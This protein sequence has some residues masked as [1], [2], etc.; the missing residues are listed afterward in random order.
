MAAP[1]HATARATGR[2]G[3]LRLIL[4]TMLVGSFWRR[5]AMV[6]LGLMVALA[7]P[8]L[9]A[10]LP[11]QGHLLYDFRGGLYNAGVAILHGHSP[12]RPGFLTH[13]AAIMRAGGVALG[14][15]S[16]HPFSIPVYPALANVAVVPLSLLPLWVAGALYSLLS[17]AAMFIGLRLLGVRDRRCIAAV[18]LSWPFLYG[19]Y[20]GAIGP[21]L[22]LGAGIAW[23]WRD[24]LWPPALAIATIVAAK[25]FPWTLAVWLL[26]TRRWRALALTIAAG[27]VL[28][29]GA[30]ALIGFH[31]LLQY[32]RMLSE[33]SSLQDGRADSIVTVLLVAGI[34][35][36]LA[37][38]I[39]IAAAAAIL[40]LAWRVSRREDGD[41]RA[42]G[43]A[44]L[45]ALASTPIVWDHY[46]VLLFVPIALA[47][48]RFSGLWLGPLVAPLVSLL[49]YAVIQDSHK[50]QAA[51]PNALRSA[52]PYLVLQLLIGA[53]LITT[54][55]QR[56]AWRPRLLRRSAALP[57][58][59]ASSA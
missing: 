10:T 44:V 31:G 18:A 21:F 33:V 45:A 1:A 54:P 59:A 32:P 49:S 43:L 2:S 14:E 4:A 37:S 12:Y 8:A 57:D 46:M 19:L 9:L 3:P 13:Q 15:T 29:F 40:G 6:M 17:V 48:P 26:V 53:V 25:I 50:V 28:T 5:L 30:W 36:S 58:V 42:L 39:A 7:G 55:E 35:S 27:L 34:S 52:I 22:V 41:R 16:K 20:L 24:R 47:S 56:A 23:R 51:S 38:A 11:A